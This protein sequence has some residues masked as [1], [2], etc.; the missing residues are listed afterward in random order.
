MWEGQEGP[1]RSTSM[2][3]GPGQNIHRPSL[4]TS[5]PNR[6]EHIHRD[7]YLQ[8][9]EALCFVSRGKRQSPKGSIKRRRD[10]KND[11]RVQ[12]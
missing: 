9:C 6:P 8:V 7:T 3:L 11:G 4:P 1:P 2:R 12:P 5:L 10:D